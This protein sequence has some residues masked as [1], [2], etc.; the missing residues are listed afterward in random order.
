MDNIMKI[1]L[2]QG[3]PNFSG[4][5]KSVLAKLDSGA[6]KLDQ[7]LDDFKHSIPLLEAIGLS[8]QAVQLDMAVPPALTATVVGDISASNPQV[9]QQYINENADKP[10]LVLILKGF[11]GAYEINGKLS[12][13]GLNGLVADIK[14]S[15]PPS[16]SVRM[17]NNPT[18]Q[19]G[20]N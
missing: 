11:M 13:L 2:P 16:V 5:V 15:V 3:K 10:L 1:E 9:I 6:A 4:D 20:L 8:I 7:A 19:I 14:L 12:A 17:L 18:G